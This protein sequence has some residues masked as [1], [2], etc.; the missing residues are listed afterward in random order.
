MTTFTRKT[1][2]K[3][4]GNS[5]SKEET[6]FDFKKQSKNKYEKKLKFKKKHSYEE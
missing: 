2:K 3:E 5:F 1:S 6:F 4:K